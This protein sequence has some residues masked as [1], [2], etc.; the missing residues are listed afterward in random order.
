MATPH[1]IPEEP[2]VIGRCHLCQDRFAEIAYCSAC[3]HWFCG[4]CRRR[5][6]D[7]GIEFL[8]QLIGGRRADC[9]GPCRTE[10]N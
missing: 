10:V 8:R 1:V 5:W 4:D 3:E 7:R 6:F 9:C 2:V